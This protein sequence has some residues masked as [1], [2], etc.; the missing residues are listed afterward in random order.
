MKT[1]TAT[2]VGAGSIGCYLGGNL[3]HA[4]HRVKMLGRQR[5]Q[6]VVADHG[7]KLS[8]FA[9]PEINL[10][11]SQIN[12]N[13]E[14]T[15]SIDSDFVFICV[16]SGDTELTAQQLAPAIDNKSIIVSMQ[17]GV[18]NTQTLKK[19]LPNNKVLAGMVPFNVF[20][21]SKGH[22]HQ[23]TKGALAIEQNTQ[24]EHISQLFQGSNMEVELHTDMACVQWTKLVMNLNNA[25]NAL[26]G[27]PLLNQLHNPDYRKVMADVISEALSVLENANIKTCRVGNVIP[28]TLPFILRLPTWA[29]KRIASA[30]LAID[31]QARSSMYEDLSLKRLTE[32]D[33]L[34][35]EIVALAN[36]I[37]RQA[38]INEKIVSL[39]KKAEQQ[40]RGSP[41][42]SAQALL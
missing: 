1:Y 17:N 36:S 15:D 34:N 18:R 29:F 40:Q 14:I 20:N 26:S 3:I 10:A 19:Y 16:K 12:F 32:I 39:V 9:K 27:L 30:M 5:L 37:G 28:N 22:F 42:L 4:G 8:H 24:A 23:G 38:P 25:V 35:G 11:P 2:V 21:Q 33:F 31:D 6:K 13:T 7:L 41:E